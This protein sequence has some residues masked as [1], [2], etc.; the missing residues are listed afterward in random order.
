MV[1]GAPL[2]LPEH[3]VSTFSLPL[4]HVLTDTNLHQMAVRHAEFVCIQQ[5]DTRSDDERAAE[6][7]ESEDR[8]RH[9]FRTADLSEPLM[10]RLYGAVLAYRRQ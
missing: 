1:L 4:G 7:A 5:E 3:G 9:I 2:M 10:A 8:V 6:I